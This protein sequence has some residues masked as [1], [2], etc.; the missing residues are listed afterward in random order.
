MTIGQTSNTE[1]AMQ[2]AEL[3]SKYDK[4]AQWWQDRH[5]DSGYGIN[6]IRKA[7]TFSQRGGKALDVGCGAGGRVVRLVQE[8]DLQVTDI[9]VSAEMVK[10]ARVQH[11]DT[12]FIHADIC[13]WH[14]D[15]RFDFIVAWDSI[16][17]LPLVQQK[18]VVGKLCHLLPA[19]GV[20]VYTF[21]DDVGDHTDQ[22]HN[23]TFYYSSIGINGNLQL[24]MD[25][26]L[27]VQHFELDQYPEKHAYVIARK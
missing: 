8:H 4:I 10:L 23:D 19:D 16:F 14:T 17:H 26:G 13:K 7:L 11:P 20:L 15:E 21:G 1:T 3:G 6:Q 9:D 24:L 5:Q 12:R 27:F 25:N 2:P 18:P 22:W